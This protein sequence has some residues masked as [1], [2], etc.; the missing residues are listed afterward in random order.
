MIGS[1]SDFKSNNIGN[2]GGIRFAARW[3]PQNKNAIREKYIESTILLVCPWK[4]KI[5]AVN[6]GNTDSVTPNIDMPVA[7][8]KYIL[9]NLIT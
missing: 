2:T 5:V 9:S 1:L 7:V 6:D 8:S 4:L 3:E